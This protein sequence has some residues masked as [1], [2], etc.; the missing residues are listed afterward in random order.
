MQS[1]A[2]GAAGK[3][4]Y[5]IGLSNA[6]ELWTQGAFF[7]E[8]G[9]ARCPISAFGGLQARLSRDCMDWSRGGSEDPRGD[10][11]LLLHGRTPEPEDQGTSE[12]PEQRG[13][14]RPHRQRGAVNDLFQRFCKSFREEAAMASPLASRSAIP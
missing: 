2:D 9:F 5:F 11:H 13:D 6:N 3:R 7:G 12:G 1:D 8:V 4:C 14:R 10:G